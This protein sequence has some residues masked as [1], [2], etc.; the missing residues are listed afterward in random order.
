[1]LV[2]G[3]VSAIYADEKKISVILPEYDNVVTQPLPIYGDFNT[4]NFEINDFVVVFAFND[5][6]NDLIILEKCKD[7]HS[8]LINNISLGI[9][10]DGNIY[11]FVNN[12]KVGKGIQI[13]GAEIKEISNETTAV[14]GVAILGKMILGQKGV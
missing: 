14:L 12:S 11:L 3:I 7:I 13:T 5:D 9:A 6:L 2:K 4:S 8:Y 10:E 1:M